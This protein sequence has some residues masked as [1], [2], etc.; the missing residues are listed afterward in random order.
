MESRK[1][2]PLSSFPLSREMVNFEAHREM[3]NDFIEKLANAFIK[4]YEIVSEKRIKDSF[5]NLA[6]GKSDFNP[7]DWYDICAEFVLSNC[8]HNILFSYSQNK[9]S[10]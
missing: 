5:W 6:E 9:L 7:Y 10:L 3:I 2:Y 8:Q 1:L 4:N